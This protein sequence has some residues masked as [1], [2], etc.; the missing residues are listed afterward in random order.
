MVPRGG[1]APQAPALA[2][3]TASVAIAPGCGSAVAAA[4]AAGARDAPSAGDGAAANVRRAVSE[5]ATGPV[6]LAEPPR[7]RQVKRK[8]QREGGTAGKAGSSAGGP[9]IYPVTAKRQRRHAAGAVEGGAGEALGAPRRAAGVLRGGGGQTPG[10]SGPLGG[11]AAGQ[12]QRTDGDAPGGREPRRKKKK[13]AAE[14]VQLAAISARGEPSSSASGAAPAS[15]SATQGP[16]AHAAVKRAERRNAQH[17]ARPGTAS[18]ARASAEELLAGAAGVPSRSAAAAYPAEGPA[19]RSTPTAQPAPTP[20]PPD[21]VKKPGKRNKFKPWVRAAAPEAL[22]HAATVSGA[23][24]VQPAAQASDGAAV[25]PHT[26]TANGAAA[27]PPAAA[28]DGAAVRLHAAVAN[29][30]A[31]AGPCPAAAKAAAPGAQAG[32][33]THAK[34]DKKRQRLQERAHPEGP[35]VEAAG[36][37]AR[38]FLGQG[39]VAGHA[40]AGATGLGAP[41]QGD[42]GPGG[43]TAGL[44]ARPAR[45]AGSEQ[46]VRRGSNP[47]PE[48]G[49]GLLGAMRARL[50]GGRFRWL[51]Q[52][53]YMAPSAEAHALMQAQ[54]ELYEQYH[55]VRS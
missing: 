37:K 42:P 49:P 3:D 51:N 29:R 45:K 27:K 8:A 11:V 46:A 41:C 55:E 15:R 39:T 13:A 9:A 44:V 20:H 24:A 25:R 52:R 6:A 5:R 34:S 30:V 26:G 31:H 40:A 2:G 38:R 53:L 48:A 18:A 43:G 7:R 22:P 35:G 19:A 4:A 1:A 47:N 14:R 16:A 12:E 17:A 28:V 32:G 36:S 33:L 50:A 10:S 54:P 23:A 21:H